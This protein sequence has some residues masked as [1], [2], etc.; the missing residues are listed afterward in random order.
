M[1]NRKKLKRE[2]F[3]KGT[4][5]ALLFGFGLCCMIESGFLKHTGAPWYE[6]VLAGT[7]SLCI[8]MAGLVYLIKAGISGHELK[9]K[10]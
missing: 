5:G 2:W 9:K 1:P 7:I 3:V 6:W 4:L 8:T 10:N